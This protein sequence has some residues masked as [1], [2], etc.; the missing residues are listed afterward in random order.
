MTLRDNL[1][2]F[3][4]KYHGEIHLSLGLVTAAIV[5]CLTGANPLP[6]LLL[7]V[8]GAFLPDIDHIFF[9]FLYGRNTQYAT[10]ARGILFSKGVVDYI[11]YCKINHKNN[12]KIVSHNVILP[13]LLIGL[14]IYF[15]SL[16]KPIWV[17]FFI[18]NALHFVFDMLED[19]LYFGKLNG[20]WWLKF[21]QNR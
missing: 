12:T 1:K 19:L 18:S 7:S 8:V 10:E 21:G 3:S 13:L 5:W 6:L 9:L 4:E 16:H 2:K 17:A 20:N 14:A 11:K 15:G